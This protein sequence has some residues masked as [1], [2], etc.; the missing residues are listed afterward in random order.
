MIIETN[1]VKG[2]AFFFMLKLYLFPL[3]PLLD[4]VINVLEIASRTL[5]LLFT[6]WQG[7]VKCK[8]LFFSIININCHRRKM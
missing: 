3:T 8:S 2:Q 1:S 7:D 4:T 6:W 5:I